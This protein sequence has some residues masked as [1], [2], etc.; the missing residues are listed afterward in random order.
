MDNRT[1]TGCGTVFTPTHG[2][3][4]CCSI[5]CRKPTHAKVTLTCDGCGG[6]AVKYRQ[7]QRYA[8][9]Y[10]GRLCRDYGS[11]GPSSCTIPK[12][13]WARWY[14]RTS[15]WKPS[16]SE[17]GTFFSGHCH[18]CGDLIVELAYGVPSRWC[19]RTCER[20]VAKR[21]RR[22]REYGAPGEFRYMQVMRQYIKQ[23]KVCAYCKEQCQELPDP[24]HVVP[25][26]RGG[27]NSMSNIVAAC[28]SCNQD[29]RNLMLHEWQADRAR[30]G[31]SPVDTTLLG[32]EYMHLSLVR[33]A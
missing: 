15:D 22:A 3:Q 13:H 8:K 14:G 18:E 12:D 32:R 2:R 29:K 6:P 30:R 26:S 11:Y 28:R 20:R 25:L 23:G 4:R 24:E 17:P 19:S 1:C 7:A 5:E 9:V 10:C 33:A 27:D 16:R 21:I 31:L